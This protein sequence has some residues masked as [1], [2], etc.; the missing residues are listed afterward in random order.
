MA[1]D[2]AQVASKV[3]NTPNFSGMLY[4]AAPIET[5]FLSLIG[6]IGGV[7]AK[8]TTNFEFAVGSIYD[9]ETATQP[10]I[11]EDDSMTA[12]VPYTVVR[13]QE[14]NVTQTHQET[15]EVTYDKMANVGR[16][17]GINTAGQEN[18]VNDELNFQI[19]RKMEKIARDVEF[20]FLNGEF[21]KATA[22][23]VANKT[24][25]MISA[26]GTQKDASNTE[27]SYELIMD[28]MEEAWNNGATFTN[29]YFFT[30]GT[31]KRK[32]T[33]IFQE[34]KGFVLPATRNV[35]GINITSFETDFGNV[36]IVL[37]KF[38]PKNTILGADL[39]V[40]VPVEQIVPGKG[41]FFLETLSKD[42]ASERRQIYG[43]IGLDY[44]ANFRHLVIKNLN[45]P[46]ARA[47]TRR[48]SKES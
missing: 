42:G 39:S 8:I 45:I 7:N 33:S 1:T 30:N 34:L 47:T 43:K 16:M 40:I 14:V 37:D 29:F 41:N 2:N 15:V 32:L 28:A 17:S 12:P 22:S 21:A 18:N 35:G 24:R 38:M 6:G 3:F 23:N 46:A 4:S 9:G 48:A 20:S 19:A 27:L 5:P 25:G 13:T 44:G 26:A 36:N 11:S 10:S 31:Q